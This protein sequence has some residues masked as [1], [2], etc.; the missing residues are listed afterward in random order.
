MNGVAMKRTNYQ[1]TNVTP[2]FAI[3]LTDN[4]ELENG[5]LIAENQAG[6]YLPIAA[7]IS[8]AEARELAQDDFRRRRRQVERDGVDPMYPEVYKV[9]ARGWDGCAVAAVFDCTKF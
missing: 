9:W 2:G 5:M 6:S 1:P 3:Q 4:T 7:V 8:I